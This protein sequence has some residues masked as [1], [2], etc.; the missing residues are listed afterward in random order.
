MSYEILEHSTGTGTVRAYRQ[1]A[2]FAY[3]SRKEF[4]MSDGLVGRLAV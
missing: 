2:S 4:G 1:S 3:G